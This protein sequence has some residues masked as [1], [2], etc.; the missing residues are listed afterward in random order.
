MGSEMCIRDRVDTVSAEEDIDKTITFSGTDVDGDTLTYKITTLPANGYLFQT[1]DG[2]TRGDTIKNVPTTVTDTT[3]V[4]Y[5][6]AKDGYGDGHGNFGFKAFD[7]TSDSQEATIV[8]NVAPK[9][10]DRE[11]IPQTISIIEDKDITVTLIGAD[12]DGDPLTYK[13][14]TLPINGNLFETNDG[15]TRGDS[16]LSV[17]KTVSGPVHRVIYVPY[18]D[19]Y[20]DDYGNFGF[21]VNDGTADG[22]EAVVTIN[23][24]AVNDPPTPISILSPADSIDIIITISNKDLSLIHI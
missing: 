18:K 12:K 22:L 15:L 16:I 8:V 24:N 4:I 1:S 23:V 2:V 17:P 9:V 5:V 7:G 11:A 6:S 10:E 21:K 19:G 13:I 3:R 20:G 14:T